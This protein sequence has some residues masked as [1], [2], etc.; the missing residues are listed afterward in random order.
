MD[1][2]VA[3]YSPVSW[4]RANEPRRVFAQIPCI[5]KEAE[6]DSQ[7][8]LRSVDS[9]RGADLAVPIRKEA[10]ERVGNDSRD[11]NIPLEPALQL[12][13]ISQ[14]SLPGAL[15]PTVGLS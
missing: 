15:A 3:R 5:G 7:G 11:I 2:Q 13:Q 14:V 8:R 12:A 1:R 6:K 10:S 9:E 4:G